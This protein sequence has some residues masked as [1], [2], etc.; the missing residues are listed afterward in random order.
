MVLRD[1]GEVDSESST[2]EDTSSSSSEGESS[3]KTSYYEGDFLVVRRIMSSLVEVLVGL[4]PLIPVSLRRSRIYFLY[5]TMIPFFDLATSI[6]RKYLKDPMS[7]ILNVVEM[8]LFNRDQ[9]T[10]DRRTEFILATGENLANCL[11][12]LYL[13]GNLFEA[14]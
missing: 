3:I 13:N 2:Q 9:A 5:E 8:E 7:L 6:P 1:N 4:Q 10:R 14:F 12:L 11:T